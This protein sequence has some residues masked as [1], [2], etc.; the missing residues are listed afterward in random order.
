MLLGLLAYVLSVGP[1]ALL[2]HNGCLP[3]WVLWVYLPLGLLNEH[4]DP[5]HRALRWYVQLWGIP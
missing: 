5:A 1:I 2:E 4:S 3:E